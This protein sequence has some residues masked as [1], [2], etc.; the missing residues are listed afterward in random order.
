M[1][2]I[3]VTQRVVVDPVHG[4][5]RD[6][7]DQRWTVFLQVC[8]LTPIILP[9]N[10]EIAEHLLVEMSLDGVLLTGGGN[11]T[12]YGG[13]AAERD[14]TEHRL[15]E[16]ARSSG[17]PVF[18]VCRGMEVLLDAF[19]I[20]LRKVCGHAAKVHPVEGEWGR[21]AVN[22]FHDLAAL[23]EVEPFEVVAYSAGGVVEGI[24]HPYEPLAGVMW[25]PE[26]N[27]PIESADVKLITT[28][29]GGCGE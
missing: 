19:D 16:R 2:L 18:G 6:A 29:F 14:R 9:N 23:N 22:S 10:A 1:G 24:R 5:R 11:L 13:D 12:V 20:P 7:L 26:R 21:E 4:E 15:L 8:G 3:G 27:D 25:H 17:L 28:F